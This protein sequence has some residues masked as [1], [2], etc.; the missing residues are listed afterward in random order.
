M[1]AAGKGLLI[2]AMFGPSLNNN[3][4]DWSAGVSSFWFE[5]GGG[6]LSGQEITVAGNLWRSI[7]RWSRPR[8][9]ELQLDQ[10]ASALLVDDLAIAGEPSRPRPPA[11]R[12]REAA[13]LAR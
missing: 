10:H 2:T 1:K 11:R 6:R 7:A 4:G 3:T 12:G 5:N 8:D 9:L 13:R